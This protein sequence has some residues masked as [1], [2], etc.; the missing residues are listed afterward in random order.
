MRAH[1]DVV[2]P[3]F[4]PRDEY[5]REMQRFG[6]LPPDLGPDDP[7]DVY[8]TDRRYWESFWVR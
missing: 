1:R 8:E 3:D 6:F 4:R 7:I 2:V 5:I